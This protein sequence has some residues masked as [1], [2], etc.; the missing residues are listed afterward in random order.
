MDAKR[1]HDAVKDF[2]SENVTGDSDMWDDDEMMRY[3]NFAQR[4]ISNRRDMVSNYLLVRIGTITMDG[5]GVYDLP[6][7]CK[8]VSQ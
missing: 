6:A 5:T 1:L 2:L 7:D 3:L 8:R 4:Y